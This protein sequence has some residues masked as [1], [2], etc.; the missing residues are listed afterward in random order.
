MML[1]SVKKMV[2]LNKNVERTFR[3]YGVRNQNEE[4]LGKIVGVYPEIFTIE[5]NNKMI[6]CFSYSDLLIKNLEII[7]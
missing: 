2:V 5:L 3:F 4:F 6:K 7:N 1:D